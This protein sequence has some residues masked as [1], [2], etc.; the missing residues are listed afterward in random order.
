MFADSPVEVYN[1]SMKL[2]DNLTHVP[3][4]DHHRPGRIALALVAAGVLFL[5]ALAIG[6]MGFTITA[7]LLGAATGGA[8]AIAIL[9][10]VMQTKRFWRWVEWYSQRSP[11]PRPKN[12]KERVLANATTYLLIIFGVVML[13]YSLLNLPH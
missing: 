12:L 10:A 2:L 1:V 11:R 6:S 5:L 3:Q 7:R 13:V 4:A 9:L 8:I